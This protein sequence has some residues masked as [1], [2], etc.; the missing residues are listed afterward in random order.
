[1]K[2]AKAK[3][4][5][6]PLAGMELRGA[7]AALRHDTPP[8]Q[9]HAHASVDCHPM[10]RVVLNV[11]GVRFETAASTLTAYPDTLLGA[12]FSAS[13]RGITHCDSKGEYFFDR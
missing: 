1:M 8:S 12:M 6:T 3:S 9:P 5:S 4:I 11:G 7:T 13:S 10:D 2:R